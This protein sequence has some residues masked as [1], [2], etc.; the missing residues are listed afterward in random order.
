MCSRTTSSYLDNLP[1]PSFPQD[2]PISRQTCKHSPISR[3]ANLS[4]SEWLRIITMSPEWVRLA[5][6]KFH[7]LHLEG[8]AMN[9]MTTKMEV[10]QF[11]S[12]IFI[13]ISSSSSALEQAA[14][15]LRLPWSVCLSFYPIRSSH[16]IFKISAGSHHQQQH[17]VTETGDRERGV[18][19][20]KLKH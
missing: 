13:I 15:R 14:S 7:H 6:V 9:M 11:Q 3:F 10:I 18:L 5:F 12:A 19:A 8:W 17:Q 2:E 1:F 16:Y 20:Q 4:V